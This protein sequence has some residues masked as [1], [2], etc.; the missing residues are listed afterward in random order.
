MSYAQVTSL[1]EVPADITTSTLEELIAKSE[2]L[3]TAASYELGERYL[4]G[5]N[6]AQKDLNKAKR[7]Y[8]AA[9]A[10]QSV[11]HSMGLNGVCSPMIVP[12]EYLEPASKRLEEIKIILE[13][14]NGTF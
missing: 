12:S 3:N 4:Y 13:E 7:Y 9:T 6:G 14:K 11:G 8:F 2:G 10:P 5:I 1:V